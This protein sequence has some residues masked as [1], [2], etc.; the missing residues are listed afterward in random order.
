MGYYSR[1]GEHRHWEHR[2]EREAEL[3]HH[4]GRVLLARGS[5]GHSPGNRLEA[6]RL[7]VPPAQCADVHELVVGGDSVLQRGCAGVEGVRT[8][9]AQLAVADLCF[10]PYI[11]MSELVDATQTQMVQSRLDTMGPPNYR[12]NRQKI[13]DCR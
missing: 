6:P 9:D 7:A 11:L 5:L 2:Q 4:M 8:I 3:E 10:V 1:L 13:P 12:L